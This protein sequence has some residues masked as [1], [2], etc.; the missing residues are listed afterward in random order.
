MKPKEK[1]GHARSWRYWVLI[2]ISTLAILAAW[3]AYKFIPCWMVNSCTAIDEPGAPT[4]MD[5]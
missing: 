4:P 5:G 1:V 3:A 2:A